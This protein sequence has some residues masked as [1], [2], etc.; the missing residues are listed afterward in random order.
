MNIMLFPF[1]DQI[2]SQHSH[3]RAAWHWRQNILDNII[4]IN[5]YFQ[6]SHT[7]IY[8][9]I[10]VLNRQKYIR[11]LCLFYSINK[12]LNIT[13]TFWLYFILLIFKSVPR[14]RPLAEC[15]KLLQTSIC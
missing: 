2:I 5:F 9:Y 12:T 10:Y 14:P 15:A 4:I 6:T 1:T 3:Y 7:Y 8:I 11:L 13:E